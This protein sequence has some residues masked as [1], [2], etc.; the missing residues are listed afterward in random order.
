MSRR[1]E[2]IYKRKD[3]RWEGRYIKTHINHKAKYGYVYARTYRE[4]KE[5]L[6]TAIHQLSEDQTSQPKNN[7]IN[8]QT[9]FEYIAVEWLNSIEPFLKES[10]IVKYKNL[11]NRYLL[12]QYKATPINAITQESFSNYLKYLLYYGGSKQKGLSSKTI[13]SI[14]SVT[15]SIFNY[16]EEVHVIPVNRIQNLRIKQSS[17]N[18]RVLSVSEQQI[19]HE[20]LV[21]NLTLTNIGILVCLYTG[22]RIGE[23]CALKWSDISFTDQYIHVSK[24]MQRIQVFD[25]SKSRTY[26]S[27]SKPKS[28]S[29]IRKIPIPDSI[30]Q[31]LIN[32]QGGDEEFILTGSITKFIEPRTMQNRFKKVIDICSIENANFHS[33]RHTFATRCIELGFDY[34]SL[35]EIL[36]HSNVIIK[37]YR[38]DG[39]YY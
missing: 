36:G 39:I 11:L 8:H 9:D 18:L 10:S 6:N 12:P 35:S 25:D 23:L 15:K 5:K 38:S 32:V 4:V 30:F 28:E 14:F 21:Q 34:K 7:L 3:G 19:L 16:A 17:N 29:S 31:F 20:Y 1:G 26:I 13:T 37:R 22:I 33:L 24:T 2:N 27:V